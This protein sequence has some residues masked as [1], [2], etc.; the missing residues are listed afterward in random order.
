MQGPRWTV[1]SRQFFWL[2]GKGGV[3]GLWSEKAQKGTWGGG[4]GVTRLAIPEN[5][6]SALPGVSGGG[7]KMMGGRPRGKTQ[8]TGQ[9]NPHTTRSEGAR[10][11]GVLKGVSTK[12]KK[13]E[14]YLLIGEASKSES[15]RQRK[16]KAAQGRSGEGSLARRGP[17]HSGRGGVCG[18][19]RGEKTKAFRPLNTVRAKLNRL[20]QHGKGE[21]GL[22][23]AASHKRVKLV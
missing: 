5:E 17:G 1:W 14:F 9:F 8:P 4:G 21:K 10:N 18:D 16:G 12:G 20:K 15:A 3:A 22:W 23:G 2:R 7:R 6:G 11:Q 19:P 13:L